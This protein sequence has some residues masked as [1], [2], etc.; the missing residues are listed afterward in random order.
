MI[1]R[2]R[3]KS[4]GSWKISRAIPTTPTTQTRG[5]GHSRTTTR[6]ETRRRRYVKWFFFGLYLIPRFF[7][8]N[9]F[10]TKSTT[11]TIPAPLPHAHIASASSSV[12]P[13]PF[14]VPSRESTS[15]PREETAHTATINTADKGDHASL[16]REHEDEADPAP[17]SDVE[18]R[19]VGSDR[20]RDQGPIE[21]CPSLTFSCV[22]ASI[23]G[24][25]E[26]G[27]P[28]RRD[29]CRSFP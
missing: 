26:P 13:S 10:L 25:T 7:V 14:A 19:A 3:N 24:V 27:L 12:S 2:Y 17:G 16:G 1:I 20:D 23:R 6:R 4:A 28:R 9:A 21:V 15:K 11:T 5:C 22:R 8:D 18:M 29:A